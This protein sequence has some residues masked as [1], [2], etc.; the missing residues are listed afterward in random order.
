M[1][2]LT[3]CILP[4]HAHRLYFHLFMYS[5]V[6]LILISV[7]VFKFC[8]IYIELWCWRRLLRVPW[9][10]RG[11]NQSVIKEISAEYSL[12]GLIL[13][14]ILILTTWCK[15]LTHWKRPWWWERLKA[16]GKG[17]DRGWGDRMASQTRWT[18]V[19]A[20]FVN[21]WWIERPGG[22]WDC[23]ESDITEQLNWL[24]DI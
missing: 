21:W 1:D 11:S 16:G 22:P 6:S 12:K 7:F 8:Y 3:T 23:K 20:S 17:D 10:A 13:K 4:V 15:E 18:W 24:T 5:L 2:I 19:W 14:L 9:T